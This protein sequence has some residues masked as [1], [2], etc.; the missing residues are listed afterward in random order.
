MKLQNANIRIIHH[1]ITSDTTL[2]CEQLFRT[3]DARL[4]PCDMK[5][6]APVDSMGD[7]S[8]AKYPELY[9]RPTDSDRKRGRVRGVVIDGHIEEFRTDARGEFV[10][11]TFTPMKFY[12]KFV[13]PS[14]AKYLHTVYS[15]RFGNSGGIE[16]VAESGFITDAHTGKARKART[17]K[18]RGGKRRAAK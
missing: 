14:Y 18:R 5:P 2:S 17:K 9:K 16:A 7:A 1:G 4:Q 11:V 15:A 3:T 8:P 13:L 12:E 10:P 6:F